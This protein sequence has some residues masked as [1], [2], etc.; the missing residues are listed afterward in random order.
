[1]PSKY[2]TALAELSPRVD[3]SRHNFYTN[4]G[5]LAPALKT[6][7]SDSYEARRNRSA[8]QLMLGEYTPW[9]LAGLLPLRS[10]AAPDIVASSWMPIHVYM[11]LLDDVL[12]GQHPENAPEVLIASNLLLQRGTSALLR[13]L[14]QHPDAQIM[15]DKYFIE[16]ANAI[17]A[18]LLHHRQHLR[19]Y[20]ENDIRQLGQKASL[21]NLCASCLL[22]ADGQTKWDTD[23]LVPVSTFATGVQLLDDIADWDEDRLVGSYTHLLTRTSLELEQMGQREPVDLQSLTLMEAFTALIVTGSLEDCLSLSWHYLKDVSVAPYLKAGSPIQSLVAQW[24]GEIGILESEVASL[25]ETCIQQQCLKGPTKIWLTE[26][27]ADKVLRRQVESVYT[28]SKI[29]AQGW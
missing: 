21:L 11:L 15:V 18:E 1:M 19:S 26:I 13:L 2:P 16:N 29:I 7:V 28:K 12:D 17:Y 10:E 8:E 25:R 6:V 24:M 27:A 9:L 4:L 5:D 14:S 3:T 22:A 23:L 20:S